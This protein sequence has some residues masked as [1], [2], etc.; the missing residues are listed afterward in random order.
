MQHKHDDV[1]LQEFEGSFYNVFLEAVAATID[2]NNDL[3]EH[4]VKKRKFTLRAMCFFAG[5]T[6]LNDS[7]EVGGTCV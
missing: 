5:I 7:T 2:V 3:V 1:A 4:P 6:N